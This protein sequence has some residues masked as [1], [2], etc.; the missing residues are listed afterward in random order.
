MACKVCG[1]ELT[2]HDAGYFCMKCWKKGNQE[3]KEKAEKK[4]SWLFDALTE[5]KNN[6]D[7]EEDKKA[8]DKL[9]NQARTYFIGF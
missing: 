9:I 1:S 8:I 2:Y 5:L 3:R 4:W 7:S 6:R